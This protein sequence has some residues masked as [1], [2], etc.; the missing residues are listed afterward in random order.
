MV[1][2][3]YGLIFLQ[4]NCS[5]LWCLPSC[6]LTCGS[7]RQVVLFGSTWPLVRPLAWPRGSQQQW[8]LASS[9]ATVVAGVCGQAWCISSCTFYA[10]D[11][12][13]WGGGNTLSIRRADRSPTLSLL[14]DTQRVL[15]RQELFQEVTAYRKIKKPSC[16]TP[17]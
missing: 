9:S 12:G 6:C 14:P 2:V 5:H 17:Q 11:L 8:L 10:V 4:R 15:G 13:F 16:Y 1:G 3:C 7:L